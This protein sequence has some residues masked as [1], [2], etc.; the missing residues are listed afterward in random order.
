MV[1]TEIGD[2]R[3]HGLKQGEQFF[4]VRFC[5][6]ENVLHFQGDGGIRQ[7]DHILEKVKNRLQPLLFRERLRKYKN[8]C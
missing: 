3:S 5:S 4:P 6:Q 2:R 1:D 8:G 7:E